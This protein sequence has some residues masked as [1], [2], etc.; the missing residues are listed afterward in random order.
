MKKIMLL[1]TIIMLVIGIDG[2]SAKPGYCQTKNPG[3][4]EISSV[5]AFSPKFNSSPT[6][7]W[8][9]LHN[10]E[11]NNGTNACR[12]GDDKYISKNETFENVYA[13]YENVGMYDGTIVDLKIVLDHIDFN[14]ADYISVGF[15]QNDIGI[16]TYS[17]SSN[18]NHDARIYFKIQYLKH[19]TNDL[20]VDGNKSFKSNITF[21]DLDYD[22]EIGIKKTDI[23]YVYIL[24]TDPM[25]KSLTSYSDVYHISS[26][27][28]N[29]YYYYTG[30]HNIALACNN[31]IDAGGT[32]LTEGFVDANCGMEDSNLGDPRF[33]VIRYDSSIM[34]GASLTNVHQAIVN[35]NTN[36]LANDSMDFTGDEAAYGKTLTD[37]K[38]KFFSQAGMLTILFKKS[39]FTVSWNHYYTGFTDA[40]FLKVGE[41][42][43]TKLISTPSNNEFHT[44]SDGTADRVEVGEKIEYQIKQEVPNQPSQF[45]Y[46][47]WYIQDSI[48]SELDMSEGVVTVE[49]SNLNIDSSNFIIE[50][51]SNSNQLTVRA[52][53]DILKNE[54]FYKNNIVTITIK[55]KVKEGLTSGTLFGN[56][57]K[58]YIIRN[59]ERK[60][61]FPSN[62]V[63]AQVA[64]TTCETRLNQIKS[65]YNGLNKGETVNDLISLYQEYSSENLNQL[66]N[67]KLNGE[68]LNLDDVACSTV[69]CQSSNEF[70]C[71]T[72]DITSSQ[73]MS[74]NIE[75]R[76]CYAN[77]NDSLGSF[78]YEDLGL[79][80]NASYSYELP[81][82]NETVY[83]GQNLWR[84][85]N[86][87]NLGILNMTVDCFGTVSNSVT[88]EIDYNKLPS[89][90]KPTFNL[91]WKTGK[92][93]KEYNMQL[94]YSSYTRT[95]N[96]DP[97][98]CDESGCVVNLS[99]TYRYPL[100]Y[101][102]SWVSK[103]IN[104]VLSK[105][106]GYGGLP[107]AIEDAINGNIES[108]VDFSFN[109]LRYVYNTTCGYTVENQILNKDKSYN[110]DFRVID[111]YN[112]FPGIE[113]NSRNTG[114]N[115]CETS[116]IGRDSSDGT[117]IIGD[118]NG[119]GKVDSDDLNVNY[120]K[121]GS[122]QY[123]N[124]IS[125]LN[126]DGDVTYSAVCNETNN[127][128]YCLLDS[129]INKNINYCKG[130]DQNSIVERYIYD[131]P[132]SSSNTP[133]Y[134]I[135]LTPADI[136]EIRKYNQ[137]HGYN[138]FNMKCE[139][140]NEKCTSNFISD[141]MDGK[142]DNLNSN[143]FDLNAWCMND[144]VL[145]KKWCDNMEV[146]E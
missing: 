75:R 39:E 69:Q 108:S 126:G 73:P 56:Q 5:Y 110:F 86:G 124:K 23:D 1:L 10:C 27:Q 51:D 30:N 25:V 71:E 81:F 35:G 114:T 72:G 107:I 32:V 132:N 14:N 33:G 104:G 11:W 82:W 15:N 90:I 43:P 136:S 49:S 88:A 115:W 67:Y 137:D 26:S 117:Y 100:N 83:A 64:N 17:N 55:G 96:S 7:S 18:N 111:T 54:N 142:I 36:Y 29:G 50:F 145:N 52:T 106:D 130:N 102:N 144:R 92:S 80:C 85:L 19:G 127:T 77:V 48:P 118:L 42:Q 143:A 138:D 98:L 8:G 112:P 113:G 133:M 21:T 45:Y 97:T 91:V 22:E 70:E 99:Y 121:S 3:S 87:R 44:N 37:D 123:D 68:N 12:R 103:G 141:W 128:D 134:S 116:L 6:I 40:G 125:D 94:S 74:S 63:S 20:I 135:T 109:A 129:Y 62:I 53:S 28:A 66:L 60:G 120:F 95:D 9:N 24:N 76:V 89:D 46:D 146:T 61:P 57:A 4:D 140:Q 34:N 41:L 131:R 139:N 122:T 58:L 38:L 47:N 101:Q 105:G 84:T 93:N 13:L 65:N 78:V 2:V 59:S 119:D 16:R 79:T 31:Q